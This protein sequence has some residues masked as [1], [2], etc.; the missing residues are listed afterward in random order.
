MDRIK[1]LLNKRIGFFIFS[2]ILF[3]VKTYIAYVVEFNLG[4]TGLFQ[5]IILLFNPLPTAIIFLS[6]ALYFKGSKKSYIT[7]FIV[8]F[9]LSFWLYANILYYREFSDF[10]T[11]SIAMGAGGLTTGLVP[12]VMALLRPWDIVYWLDFII[13]IGILVVKKT[14]I[15]FDSRKFPKRYAFAATALGIAFFAGNLSMAEAD[16]PQLLERTFDRNY[17]VKYLGLNFFGGYNVYNTVQ[18]NQIR[19]QADESDLSETMEFVQDNHAEPNSEYFGIAEDRNVITIV[20]E[21]TQQFLIDYHLETPDGQQH[22]VL[23]FLNDVYHSDDTYSFSNFFHQTGQGKSSDAEVLA[24]NSLFGLSQGSAFQSLG[25][26]NTFHAAPNILKETAGYTTAAFHGNTG[27]FWNRNDTYQSFGYD[28]FFDSRFYDTSEERMHEYGV[29]D[30][31][32]FHDSAEYLQELPQPF[33]TKFL[34]VSN[35]FPYPMN[36][37]NAD[38]PE[39]NTSDETI[40]QY[41]VTNHYADQSIE[42]FFNWLQESGLYEDSIIVM[43]GDHYGISNTRNPVLGEE[44]LD[45]PQSEWDGYHD[46]QTQRVP[47][48]VHVPGAGNGQVFDQYTGQVDILPTLLHLLGINTDPYVFMGQDMLSEQNNN[49]VTL[50]NGRVITPKYTFVGGTIYDTETGEVLNDTLSEEEV[51]NLLAKRQEATKVLNHSDQVLQMD[52]LRFY[53]PE[54]LTGIEPI[55]YTYAE[56][57]QYLEN[58]PEKETSLE[59]QSDHPNPAALYQTDAPEMNIGQGVQSGSTQNGQTQQNNG[60]NAGEQ[61]SGIKGQDEQIEQNSVEVQTNQNPQQ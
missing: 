35:H 27:T 30:K 19:A 49:I 12:A 44:L 47:M 46:A 39:A 37:A 3:W 55:P 31:L 32:F 43:Y 24:E 25:S 5:N 6:L 18:N 57:M 54:T 11:A 16:R 21:S 8:Y 26:T 58:E 45:I 15:T 48:M 33:Y 60:T 29:K 20:L 9:L 40:N 41:F 38:F 17:I 50:R 10:I 56:Q 22:E 42:E 53:T 1:S 2:L 13:L 52:L 36:E 7:M 51:N 34:T 59:A 14:N 4:V 23:P 61:K 28:Y